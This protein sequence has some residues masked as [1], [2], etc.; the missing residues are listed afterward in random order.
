M[1]N[2]H[3]PLAATLYTFFFPIIES[4]V[5]TNG[6]WYSRQLI[7]I[8]KF[9]VDLFSSCH[10]RTRFVW[11]HVRPDRALSF[12]FP[13]RQAVFPSRKATESLC[14]KQ[15]LVKKEYVLRA[16]RGEFNAR[17]PCAFAAHT[18]WTARTEFE[19]RRALHSECTLD[20]RESEAHK[21]TIYLSSAEKSIVRFLDALFWCYEFTCE[22][23][24]YGL[25]SWT[26]DENA[27]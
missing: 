5:V 23:S 20:F 17:M 24:E 18:N 1:L 19:R 25:K 7:S 22:I 16:E 14:Q 13:Q 4:Q 27:S 3:C 6:H 12:A 10:K 2:I 15:I 26:V 8:C 21:E 11:I 9:L